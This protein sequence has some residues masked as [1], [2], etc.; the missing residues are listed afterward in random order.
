MGPKGLQNKGVSAILIIHDLMPW[1][2]AK[3]SPVLWHNPWARIKFDPNLW[4]GP[5]KLPNFANQRMEF[6]KGKQACEIF[7]LDSN[8]PGV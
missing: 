2:I 3:K 6:I 4:K 8:W 1:T 7:K 5:Q